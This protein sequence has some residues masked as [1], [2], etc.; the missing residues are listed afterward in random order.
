VERLATGRLEPFFFEAAVRFGAGRFEDAVREAA[1]FEEAFFCDFAVD[2]G[3][4][5]AAPALA[6]GTQQKSRPRRIAVTD[7]NTCNLLFY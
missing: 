1:G 4:L 6:L 3:R 7:L 5:E 2:A